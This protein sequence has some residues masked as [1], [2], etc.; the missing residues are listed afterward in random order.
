ML[1][2]VSRCMHAFYRRMRCCCHPI[3]Q[4]GCKT[5]LGDHAS[6]MCTHALR[7]IHRS[8]VYTPQANFH[9]ASLLPVF[10]A[11]IVQNLCTCACTRFM[12]L[13]CNT[14]YWIAIHTLVIV[15]NHILTSIDVLH[16]FQTYNT[17]ALLELFDFVCM[18]AMRYAFVCMVAMRFCS[19]ST[20]PFC[21]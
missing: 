18:V 15:R 11:S 5:T 3:Y 16:A 17:H 10:K 13:T 7:C 8:T 20:S 9:D 6:M 2:Y 4:V 12:A 14:A 1:A 21:E 19:A